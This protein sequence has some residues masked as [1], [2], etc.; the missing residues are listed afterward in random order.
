MNRTAMMDIKLYGR[1]RL[2]LARNRVWMEVGWN[3]QVRISKG[4]TPHHSTRLGC[5]P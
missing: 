5:P 3:G 4:L 2:E 1:E